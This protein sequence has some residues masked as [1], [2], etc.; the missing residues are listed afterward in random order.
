MY[1]YRLHGEILYGHFRDA[2]EA[3]DGLNAVARSHGWRELTT[4]TPTVGRS[5]TLVLEVEYPSLEEFKRETE[6]TA[7]DPEYMKGVRTLSQWTVQGSA[8][9][10]LWEA[11]PDLA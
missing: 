9:D 2:M 11:A 1:R 4:W 5:N 10:E 3:V 8:H 7:S 6:A